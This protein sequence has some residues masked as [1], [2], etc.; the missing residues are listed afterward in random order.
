M[1]VIH[2]FTMKEL[3]QYL[4]ITFCILISFLILILDFYK[5]TVRSNLRRLT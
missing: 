4:R 3:I 2:L 1:Y 5:L